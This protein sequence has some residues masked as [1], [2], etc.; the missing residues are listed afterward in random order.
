MFGQGLGL[1]FCLYISPCLL[2]CS[3]FYKFTKPWYSARDITLCVIF[4]LGVMNLSAVG[5]E[6]RH[7]RSGRR[8][9]ARNSF[10]HIDSVLCH[11][12][13]TRLKNVSTF[14]HRCIVALSWEEKLQENCYNASD[15]GKISW[16]KLVSQAYCRPR[17]TART[18]ANLS[19]WIR[20]CTDKT[21]HGL[22]VRRL[23]PACQLW[24]A[25]FWTP[26]V[27]FR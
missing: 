19:A 16:R 3:S 2:D 22:P 20:M 10:R 12:V 18:D 24:C 6:S 5:R 14:K 17:F 9:A 8:R 11:V 27:L 4:A 21:R 1:D 25:I 13:L 23:C 26:Y 7:C 15:E